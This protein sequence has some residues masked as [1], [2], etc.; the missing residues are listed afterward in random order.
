MADDKYPVTSRTD[1]LPEA[2]TFPTKKKGE[3]FEDA[4]NDPNTPIMHQYKGKST[5]NPYL[6]YNDDV[7]E[8]DQQNPYKGLR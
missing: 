6:D 2:N 3:S 4:A 8:D 7:G 5:I 1:V